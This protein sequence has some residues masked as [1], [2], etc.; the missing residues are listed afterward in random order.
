MRR[1]PALGA[2]PKG[3]L[4]GALLGALLIVSTVPAG[5]TGS[6]IP[7]EPLVVDIAGDAN[8]LNYLDIATPVQIPEADLLEAWFTNDRFTITAYW[9]LSAAPQKGDSVQL[10]MEANPDPDSTAVE[11]GRVSS[12]RGCLFFTVVFRTV[13]AVPD[14]PYSA[15]ADGCLYGPDVDPRWFIAYPSID[16]LE[17]GTAI[18]SARIPRNHTPAL[19]GRSVL[20]RVTAWTW[21]ADWIGG[22]R[23]TIKKY[24]SADP[25]GDYKLR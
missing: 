17:D 19:K 24:D 10:V 21:N 20:T 14:D 1:T 6:S 15:F 11:A 23:P 13:D 16:E 18:I 22:T 9:H 12:K 4:T 3:T 5:A 7:A 8:A 2:L 25:G